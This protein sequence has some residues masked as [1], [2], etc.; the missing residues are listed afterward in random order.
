[1]VSRAG[2]VASM[3]I[4]DDAREQ[5]RRPKQASHVKGTPDIGTLL[6][7]HV[8]LCF[9][10]H[11]EHGGKGG[12]YLT[13]EKVR[14]VREGWRERGGTSQINQSEMPSFPPLVPG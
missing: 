14:K 2:L 6:S 10:D 5:I 3:P 8:I 7:Q 12:D 1:M 13:N 11:W 4:L 9:K